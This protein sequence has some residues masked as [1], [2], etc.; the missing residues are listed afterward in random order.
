MPEPIALSTL[1]YPRR[2]I[3]ASPPTDSLS[4]SVSAT[5]PEHGDYFLAA[6]EARRDASAPPLPNELASL[7]TLLRYGFQPQ[8]VAV[9]IY[10]QAVLLL[11]KG[12]PF[13]GPPGQAACAAAGAAATHP[14]T[15]DGRKFVWRPA[16]AWPWRA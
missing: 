8:R 3:K 16:A 11:W 10:W 6:L 7:T 4:L 9:W 2:T 14:P 1:N 15:A 5:H 13:F 12:V